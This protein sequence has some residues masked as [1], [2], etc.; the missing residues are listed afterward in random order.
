MY[1]PQENGEVERQNKSL[2]KRLKISQAESRDWK[3]DLLDFLLMYRSTSHSTTGRS[4]AELLFGRIIKDKLP[5]I[6]QPLILDEEMRDKDKIMKEKGKEY[7]DGKRGA[8]ESSVEKGD[9]VVVKTM[10]KENKLS[11]NFSP[12]EC[13]VL[14]RS[15]SEVLVRAGSGGVYR[16]NVAHV[17]RIGSPRKSARSSRKPVRFGNGVTN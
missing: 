12:D 6:G 8:R 5:Q 10:T 17:K 11:S 15:G 9:S 1:W 14:A 4:P 16:R 2:V 7:A 13:E 3:L